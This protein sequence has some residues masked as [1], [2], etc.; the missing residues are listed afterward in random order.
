[1]YDWIEMLKNGRTSLT[2][3]E[4]SGCP[5]TQNEERVRELILQKRKVMFDEIIKKLKISIGSAY[6][7]VHDNLQLHKACA[8]WVP[9]ELT[10][11]HKRLRLGTLPATGSL[12]RRR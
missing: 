8:R 7:V 1:V 6:F 3:A 12:L 10:D 2:D 5:T 11:E 9:M 4:R